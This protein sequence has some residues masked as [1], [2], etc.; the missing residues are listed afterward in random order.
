MGKWV[1][2]AVLDG[3]LAVVA[4]ATRMVALSGQPASFAQAESGKLAEVPLLSAD[5]QLAPG[6]VSGRRIGI[7]AK[8]G[9]PVL[10][11]G[12]ADHVALLDPEANRLVYVTTC[13]PQSLSA[14]GSVNFAGW[15]IEIGDPV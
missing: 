6:E 10:A 2:E 3:A 14:G 15:S 4:S 1:S 11:G 5:F 13:P 8:S 9:V 7:S 12:T